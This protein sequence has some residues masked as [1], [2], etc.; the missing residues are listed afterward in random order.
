[1]SH[2]PNE[3]TDPPREPTEASNEPTDASREPTGASDEPTESRADEEIPPRRPKSKRKGLATAVLVLAVAVALLGALSGFGSRWGLW[4][5]RAGFTMLEW[6]AYAALAV[7]ALTLPVIWLSRPGK[8]RPTA[9]VL[10]LVALVVSVPSS[11]YRWRGDS[12]L[13]TRPPSTTSPP[14]RAI[15]HGSSPSCR[16][17]RTPPTPSSIQA[18]RPRSSNGRPTPTSV[19]SSS[20]SP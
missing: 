7:A 2:R 11:S 16:C 12:V 5:F 19:R 20:T 9:L 17:V 10:A 14:T 15:R 6:S 13:A 4:S 8:E 1:M 18:P 3:P